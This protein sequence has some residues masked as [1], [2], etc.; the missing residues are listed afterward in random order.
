MD[1]PY[2][3]IVDTSLFFTLILTFVCCSLSMANARDQICDICDITK[4]CCRSCAIILTSL[5]H[6]SVDKI[7]TIHAICFKIIPIQQ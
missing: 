5:K 7:Q 3:K 6:A 4:M 1:Q 2:E